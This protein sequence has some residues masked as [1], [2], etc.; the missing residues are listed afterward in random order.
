[1]RNAHPSLGNQSGGKICLLV[2]LPP[3]TI[4]TQPGRECA[5]MTKPS[6]GQGEI[7]TASQLDGGISE[8]QLI[9]VLVLLTCLIIALTGLTLMLCTQKPACFK[10][11]VTR[12]ARSRLPKPPP[13]CAEQRVDD[14]TANLN[15]LANLRFDI[16]LGHQIAR[17]RQFDWYLSVWRGDQVA[18]KVFK[19]AAEKLFEQEIHHFSTYILHHENIVEFHDNGHLCAGNTVHPWMFLAYHPHGSLFD[20][21]S[22]RS[23]PNMPADELGLSDMQRMISSIA[24]GLS[25]LHCS[26]KD[27]AFGCKPPIA[28]RNLKSKNIL[29]KRDGTCCISDLSLAISQ[30]RKTNGMHYVDVQD[31]KAGSTRYMA[32]E[33]LSE[34]IKLGS[35]EQFLM[36]DVYSVALIMWEIAQVCCQP[37]G[38]TP[39][40]ILPYS[41]R[42]PADPTLEDMHRTVCIDKARPPLPSR[43]RMDD[44]LAIVHRL[45][46]ACWKEDGAS[47]FTS[48][49]IY[50]NIQDVQT[51]ADSGETAV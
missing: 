26:A 2:L 15:T 8:V 39:C 19:T 11:A 28:H 20:F 10:K 48:K 33:V 40:Y 18:V 36:A 7:V 13:E 46:S 32:P 17:G 44:T 51:D 21:L 49:R 14:K 42:V 30:D 45:I 3:C 27:R 47:R 5:T 6:K 31:L 12:L 23:A 9:I 22:C 43:W 25:Y 34:T 29:V 38:E 37:A 16:D 50:L 41:H 35:F 1:M 24:T 4:H